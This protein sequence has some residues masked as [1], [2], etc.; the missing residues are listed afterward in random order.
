MKSITRRCLVRGAP[1]ATAAL[2]VAGMLLGVDA[3]RAADIAKGSRIYAQHCLACHGASGVSV[4]P[5]APNFARSERLLQPDSQLLA[6]IK[7]GRNAMPAYVGILQDREILDVIAYLR[8]LR[9]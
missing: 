1:M 4:M 2:A 3:A 8:V 5:G 6:S 9:R 7:S